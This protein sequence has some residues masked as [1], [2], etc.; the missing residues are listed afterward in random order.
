MSRTATQVSI[1][2]GRPLTDEELEILNANRG[3]SAPGIK[4]IRQT[5]RRL[6]QLLAVG[7]PDGAAASIVGLHPS[8]VSILKSD[9][10][11]QA[12]MATYHQHQ[13]QITLSLMDKLGDISHSVMD[14][15]RDRLLEEPEKI[16]N[17]QLLELLTESLDRLGHSPTQKIAVA[18]V[19]ISEL[20]RNA[21]A[22][23]ND[24]ITF[25]EHQPLLEAEVSQEETNS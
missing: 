13:E 6:A 9:P 17:S 4:S 10:A 18:H 5:H 21:T 25:R 7:T 2:E 22:A 8:R 23:R 16:S 15:I 24:Q 20:R 19:D 3:I 14:E 1:L 11:F 12:L